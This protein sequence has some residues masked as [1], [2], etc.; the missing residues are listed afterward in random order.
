MLEFNYET[1]S[2][3]DEALRYAVWDKGD[4]EFE[5][6]SGEIK[7]SKKTQKPMIELKIKAFHQDGRTRIISDYLLIPDTDASNDIKDILKYKVKHLLKSIDRMNFYG[8][9]LTR[10]IMDGWNGLKGKV[11][12]TVTKDKTGQYHDKNT[13]S[14]YLEKKKDEFDDSI[15]F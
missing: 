13:V 10:P 14:D 8:Q 9:P 3:E 12:L 1:I 7:E 2:D 4:Y 5:F 15:P 11:R 6:L